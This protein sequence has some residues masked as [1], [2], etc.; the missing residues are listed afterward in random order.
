M[1]LEDGAWDIVNA[2]TWIVEMEKKYMS[3]GNEM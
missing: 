2:K 3:R 1:Y